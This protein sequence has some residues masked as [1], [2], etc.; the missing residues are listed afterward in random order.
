[1]AFQVLL[2]QDAARDLDEIYDYVAEHDAVSKADYVLG[3]LEKT[4]DGL[5]RF[6]NRG[7]HPAELLEL[8]MREYREVF[9]KPYRVIYRVVASRVY[10][11]LIVDG[12]RDMHT[13]LLRRI[14]G[15]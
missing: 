7:P 9:F 4:I 1:M 13:L 6:P 12:R 2:T 14:L 5:A 15:A 3:R 8:G 10:V 11:Y